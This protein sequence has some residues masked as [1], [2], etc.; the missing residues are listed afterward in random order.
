VLVRSPATPLQ[1]WAVLTV[2]EFVASDPART[3]QARYVM[4]HM[5]ATLK[6]DPAWISAWEQRV[7]QTTGAVISM[8][9]AATQTA[10][11]AARNANDT[12]SRLNHPNPG[13]GRP[14]DRTG[15][16]V[17]TI[18][19]TRDVCDAIGRC[20]NVSNDAETV[21]IDHGGNVAPGRAG[22]APP[23]NSGVWS[24]MR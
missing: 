1:F 4:E 22:G 5:V 24:Q 13:V 6:K 18:L 14:A 12:L 21:F 7:R 16:R 19:G 10:L 11:R 17:N 8:Q 3:M 15:S 23:D 9:N 20:K 2:A